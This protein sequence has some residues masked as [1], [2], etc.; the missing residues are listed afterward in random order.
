MRNVLMLLIA[1][2]V[3]GFLVWALLG[4]DPPERPDVPPQPTQDEDLANNPHLL[5]KT[6]VLVVRATAPDGTVPFDTMVGFRYRDR[7]HLYQAG[8][9]GLRQIIDAPIADV[10]VIARA[11]GYKD[12]S[13]PRTLIAGVPTEVVLTL[14]PEDR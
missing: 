6:G 9:D 1:A 14:V 13:T 7:A 8:K 2:A 12:A 11:P 3:G 10:E 4:G 5:V